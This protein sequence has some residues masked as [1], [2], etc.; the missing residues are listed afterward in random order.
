MSIKSDLK[1]SSNSKINVHKEI[2][3]SPAMK[4]Q[5]PKSGHQYSFSIVP[6]YPPLAVN[7]S[8]VN[9]YHVC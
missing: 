6:I 8:V 4:Q 7:L 9:M 2:Q 1:V 3:R 5:I